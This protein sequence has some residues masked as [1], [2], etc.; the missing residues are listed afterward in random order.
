MSS[1]LKAPTLAADP[2]AETETFESFAVSDAVV[3]AP[4]PVRQVKTLHEPPEIW[5]LVPEASKGFSR[6]SAVLVRITS[7]NPLMLALVVVLGGGG[8]VFGYMNWGN[9]SGLLRAASS[10]MEEPEKKTS[11]SLRATVP[12]KPPAS[13]EQP[14]TDASRIVSNTKNPKVPVTATE[15][16]HPIAETASAPVVPMA[17]QVAAPAVAVEKSARAKPRRANLINSEPTFSSLPNKRQSQ[18]AS[19]APAS[20]GEQRSANSTGAKNAEEKTQATQ[21]SA[22]AQQSSAPARATATPKGK[23]IQWP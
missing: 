10:F 2:T 14:R 8:A 1:I 3:A 12:A 11:S 4:T 19:K 9:W 6:P 7:M 15:L 5:D 21:V 17:E 16:K 13:S 20:S 22:P 18:L 23:V